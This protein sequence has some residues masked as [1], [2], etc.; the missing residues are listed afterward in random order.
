MIRLAGRSHQELSSPALGFPTE[1]IPLLAMAGGPH[2]HFLLD[3]LGPAIAKFPRPESEAPP[4]IKYRLIGAYKLAIAT[5]RKQPPCSSLF[6]RLGARGEE[7]LAHTR[8]LG[9]GEIGECLRSASVFTW[10]GCKET[11]LRPLF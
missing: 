6:T 10:V 3:A 1:Q 4:K 2:G 7:V 9:G 8:Y 5:V 11:F